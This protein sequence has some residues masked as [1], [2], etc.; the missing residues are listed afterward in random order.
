MLPGAG[1]WAIGWR[2]SG[3]APAIFGRLR[4]WLQSGYAYDSSLRLVF[5]TY[6]D[7]PW[8]QFPHRTTVAGRPFLEVP[9]SSIRLLGFDVPIAG[10]NYFRQFPHSL[11]RRAVAHWDRHYPAP[12]V[13]YF[14]TWELDPDQPRINGVPLRQQVRQY[15]N[16]RKMPATG[17]T[18]SRELPV[19]QH[20]AVLRARRALSV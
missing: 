13:M 18:L 15:R 6:A 5:R 1:C 11:V 19:H 9:L 20:R 17:A 2:S 12:F 8:R 4:F 3:F 14:H 10:G 7:E 16:L